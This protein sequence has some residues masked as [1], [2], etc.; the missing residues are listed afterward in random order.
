MVI[1][2]KDGDFFFSCGVGGLGDHYGEVSIGNDDF[3]WG[4]VVNEF[5]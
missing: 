5:H 1:E 2:N 3:G 4:G